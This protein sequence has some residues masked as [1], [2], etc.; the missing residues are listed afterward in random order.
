MT[1]NLYSNL[2]TVRSYLNLNNTETSGNAVDDPTLVNFINRASR[3]VDA[4]TRRKFYPRYET[5]FYDLIDTKSIRLDDDLLALS[6]L[7][8]QNGA[9][10]VASEVI[11]LATGDNWNRGPW[12]KIVL[13]SDSGSALQYSG[14]PQKANEVMGWWGYNEDYS[15][16]W[17]DIGTSLLTDYTASAGSINLGGA[18]SFGTNASDVLGNHPRVAVGDLLR[19]G[20]QYFN[21]LASGSQGNQI[22]LVAPYANGTSGTSAGSGASIARFFPEPDIEW[23]TRRMA[24]WLFAGRDTPYQTKTA[25]I[26]LGTLEIP[27]G[28]AVDIKQ[29]LDKFKRRTF[30][31]YP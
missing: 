6:A 14:T 1:T 8:T 10:L 17:V 31:T 16:A 2:H 15:N 13:T 27:M 11:F 28:M 3:A 20:E 24:A 19:I 4:Y 30:Q 9:C 26:Q 21:V 29:K 22:A 25:F 12:D 23:A 5:R 7:R 18:G